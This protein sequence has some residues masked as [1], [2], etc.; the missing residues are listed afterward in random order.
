MFGHTECQLFCCSDLWP[1]FS[2][3]WWDLLKWK[4]ANNWLQWLRLFMWLI[5]SSKDAKRLIFS[6]PS[7]NSKSK[8]CRKGENNLSTKALFWMEG[9]MKWI[10]KRVLKVNSWLNNQNMRRIREWRRPYFKELALTYWTV[11]KS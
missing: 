4:L 5:F 6:T 1:I 3:Q 8:N 2:W 11:H 10:S 7:L 9:S